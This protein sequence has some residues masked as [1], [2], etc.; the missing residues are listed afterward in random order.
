MNTWACPKC[1]YRTQQPDAV[2]EVLHVCTN[3]TSVK[4]RNIEPPKVNVRAA[5]VAESL[6]RFPE[7]ACGFVLD[8]GTVV[9]AVNVA[10]DPSQNFK[11]DPA[12]ADLWWPTG[13]VVGVW[14]SHCFD[15]A[16]PSAN[17]QNLAHPDLECWIY[18]VMDEQLGIYKPDK[19]NQLQLLSMEELS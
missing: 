3:K 2:T 18:S 16:V 4:L 17:D 12:V 1:K 11:I 6:A 9:I 14:H 8:T 19:K 10:E 7:E 13:R 5:I 15:S